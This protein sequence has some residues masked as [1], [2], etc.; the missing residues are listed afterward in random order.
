MTQMNRST[1]AATVVKTEPIQKHTYQMTQMNCSKT[2]TRWHRWTALRWQPQWWKLSRYKNT[3]FR[4]HRWTALWWQPQWWKLSLYIYK[5]LTRWHRWTAL[6]HLPDD[7]DEPL[8]G[9][10]HSGENWA[11]T[12]THF[13]D[14]TDE[15]LYGDS[16][17]GENWAFT[18]TRH[19]PDDTDEL[20]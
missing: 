6:R 4:W 16:H 7:T 3:L 10:S 15:P 14:D 18:Y 20:L 9:D 11:V 5:T 12:K 8:Y 2:L 1:V 19:L 17:S 13:S